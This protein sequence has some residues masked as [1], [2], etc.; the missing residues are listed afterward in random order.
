MVVNLYF[1][2]KGQTGLLENS[3]GSDRRWIVGILHFLFH[4][5]PNR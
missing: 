1:L 5:L 4:D 2:E 3:F